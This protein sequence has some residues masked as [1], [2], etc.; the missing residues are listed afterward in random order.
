MVVRSNAIWPNIKSEPY[1]ITSFF[2]AKIEPA[3]ATKQ[4]Q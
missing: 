4:A 3:G 2:E 1:I